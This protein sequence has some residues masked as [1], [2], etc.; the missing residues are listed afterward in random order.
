MVL[1]DFSL[2][3]LDSEGE[4]TPFG[5]SQ[6]VTVQKVNPFNF[7]IEV[8]DDAFVPSLNGNPGR[9]VD[10]YPVRVTVTVTYRDPM[11]DEEQEV[12]W[13]SWVVP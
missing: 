1:E 12:A 10:D 6:R 11:R 13:V 4:E 3:G 5:W 7:S 8:A 2:L 9:D